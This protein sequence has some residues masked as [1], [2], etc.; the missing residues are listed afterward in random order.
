MNLSAR[1]YAGDN[2]FAQSMADMA[3]RKNRMLA[4]T[5]FS[6]LNSSM[7]MTRLPQLSRS[8]SSSKSAKLKL[9]TIEG[10][11]SAIS[12]QLQELRL[13]TRVLRWVCRNRAGIATS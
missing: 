3:L 7:Q 1:Q 2:I 9:T 11:L 5:G 13:E 4:S 10:T 12:Q 8:F 6:N